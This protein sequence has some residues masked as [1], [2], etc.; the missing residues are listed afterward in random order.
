M[1]ANPTFLVSELWPDRY[2]VGRSKVYEFLKRL[3]ITP[4]KPEG[5]KRGHIT[6][7]QLQDLDLYVNMLGTKG[8][9]KAQ[10]FAQ[11]RLNSAASIAPVSASTDASTVLASP[12][13]LPPAIVALAQAIAQQLQPI[14]PL[15]LLAPQRALEDAS[16]NAWHLKSRQLRSLGIYP[17]TGATVYGFELHRVKRG[18][19]AVTKPTPALPAQ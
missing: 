16:L 14:Q 18:W 9:E 19:W 6:L 5:D 10:E 15:D 2:G 13:E 3:G 17:Q 8:P 1:Q 7:D 11:K 4:F 12:T